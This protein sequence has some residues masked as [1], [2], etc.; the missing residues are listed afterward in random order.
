[1]KTLTLALVALLLLPG[2]AALQARSQLE[3]FQAH[4]RQ[5]TM[6]WIAARQRLTAACQQ[7]PPDRGCAVRAIKLTNSPRTDDWRRTWLPDYRTIVAVHEEELRRR[8]AP[9][10]YDEYVIALSKALAARADK[11]EI[12][13]EQMIRAFN[14]SWTWLAHQMRQEHL[15]LVDAIRA[16]EVADAQTAQ[17]LSAI[18]T[19]LAVVATGA[20]LAAATARAYAPPPPIHCVSLTSGYAAFITCQ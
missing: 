12:T 20:L 9:K 19:G 4:Q 5:N 14:E 7:N 3:A 13:E 11:Q 8:V 1:M 15:L 18:A 16:A 17:T 2:C 6:A 10:V